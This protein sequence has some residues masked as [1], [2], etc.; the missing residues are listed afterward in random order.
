MP[1]ITHKAQFIK[2]NIRIDYNHELGIMNPKN[3]FSN[4]IRNKLV[5]N[6]PFDREVFLSIITKEIIK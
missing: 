3:Y 1:M 5:L 4:V 6:L 2:V